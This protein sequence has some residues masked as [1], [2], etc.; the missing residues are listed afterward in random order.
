[1]QKI[2]AALLMMAVIWVGVTLHNE[3]PQQAF[4]GFFSFLARDSSPPA[5]RPY[6]TLSRVRQT[7]N[8]VDT[9][10]QD[11]VERYEAIVAE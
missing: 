8:Q 4:G 5:S 1:M 6:Q 10:L 2:F 3:G 11:D 9:A 7:A